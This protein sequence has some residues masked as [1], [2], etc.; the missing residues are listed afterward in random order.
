MIVANPRFCVSSYA[1]KRALAGKSSAA[2][3]MMFKQPCGLI[4]R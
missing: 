1:P 3:P 2:K 4:S